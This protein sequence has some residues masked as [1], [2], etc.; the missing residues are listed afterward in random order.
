MRSEM[1][2]VLGRKLL[3]DSARPLRFVSVGFL[4]S[5]VQLGLFATLIHHGVNPLA[6]NAL[7]F[8]VSVQ[9][10]FVLSSTFTWRRADPGTAGLIRRWAGFHAACGSS[11]I[12]NFMV[13]VTVRHFVPDLVASAIGIAAAAAINYTANDRLVFAAVPVVAP[14]V[15]VEGASQ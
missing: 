13:F 2:R 7:A 5:A 8:L 6:G 10:N 14:P 11:A 3:S 9:V 4:A 12:L 1:P 15:L